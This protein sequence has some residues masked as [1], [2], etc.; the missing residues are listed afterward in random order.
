MI[1]PKNGTYIPE[2]DNRVPLDCAETPAASVGSRIKAL[3]DKAVM[4]GGMVLSVTGV[5]MFF[6]PAAFSATAT[7]AVQVGSFILTGYSTAG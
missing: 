6:A 2:D 7:A 1:F 3:T 5:V 4:V